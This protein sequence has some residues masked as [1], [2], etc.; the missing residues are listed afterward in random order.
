MCSSDLI[1]GDY[2]EFDQEQFALVGRDTKTMYQL[3]D[4]IIVKVKQADL[5]KRHLD[6]ELIGKSEG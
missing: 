6:F 4:E 1:K 3:G 2:Y 5:I